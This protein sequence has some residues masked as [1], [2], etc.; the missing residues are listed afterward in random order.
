MSPVQPAP[1][2]V[3]RQGDYASL[4]VLFTPGLRS[5]LR[6]VVKASSSSYA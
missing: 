4:D 1:D 5:M 3:K 2:R 6:E